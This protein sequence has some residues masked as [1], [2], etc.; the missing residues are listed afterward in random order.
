MRRTL[1]STALALALLGSATA[2]GIRGT[3]VPVD[4]GG[5][6]SRASCVVRPEH[7]IPSG[8]ATVTVQLECTSQLVPVTR[9]VAGTSEDSVAVARVLLEE[10]RKAPSNQEAEAGMSTAVPQRL[11]VAGQRPGDPAGTLR[12]SREPAELPQVGLAQLV[13]TYAGTAAADGKRSV[14]LG[15]PAKEPPKGYACTDELRVHPDSADIT[16]TPVS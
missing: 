11:T 10:L 3:A 5:A 8:A 15:G 4:A 7:A 9:A 12:L 13:C 1:R 2:C 14:I 6:P 16:G